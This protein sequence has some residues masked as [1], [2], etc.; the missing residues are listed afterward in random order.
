MMQWLRNIFDPEVKHEE[1]GYCR[2]EW[3]WSN[4]PVFMKH[5]EECRASVF[6]RMPKASPPPPPKKGQ[7]HCCCKCGIKDDGFSPPPSGTPWPTPK[8][9]QTYR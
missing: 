2:K 4:D 3:G 9:P 8:T 5:V 7:C 6:S 1:C